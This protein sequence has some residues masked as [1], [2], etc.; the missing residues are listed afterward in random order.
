MADS[1]L[2]A[3][4]KRLDEALDRNGVEVDTVRDSSGKYLVVEPDDEK[5]V[6]KALKKLGYTVVGTPKDKAYVFKKVG[7]NVHVSLRKTSQGLEIRFLL[8]NGG[9]Y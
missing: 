4:I 7:H 9:S 6:D 2:D 5:K 1:Q 3:E 8:R